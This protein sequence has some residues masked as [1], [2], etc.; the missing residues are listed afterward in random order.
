VNF[1]SF[2]LGSFLY[3][4]IGGIITFVGVLIAALILIR[5]VRDE[6]VSLEFLSKHLVFF[7]TIPFLLG[8][9]GAFLSL[10]NS[11][12]YRLSGDFWTATVQ[13][14]KSFILIGEGGIRADWSLGGF[15][16]VFFILAFWRKEKSFVWLDTF[17]LP[18]IVVSF[19]VS[20]GGY[21]SGWGYGKPSPDWLPFPLSVEYNMA[22][23][24]YSGLPIYAVQ[25]YS[26][27]I[28]AIAFWIG[29][30][31]WRRKVWQSWLPGKF[32][33]VMV[34]FLGIT[35]SL[36]EFFRGDSVPE[37]WGIR[38]TQIFGFS[39]AF[40]ALIFLILQRNPSLLQRI[41]A[42]KKQ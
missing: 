26:A 1:S 40:I 38:I 24:R 10:W 34:F 18:G 11:L 32:F 17:I 39:I 42:R 22:E 4:S 9:F 8:R 3:I 36:L 12:E 20:I 6:E 21:F 2:P 16:I 33:A 25:L 41:G 5:T 30:N 27:F 23:V 28:F 35:N 14:I 31:L 37:P 15:F 29:W 13:I 7:I 19:F